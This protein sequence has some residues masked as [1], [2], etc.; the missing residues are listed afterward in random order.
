MFQKDP[1]SQSKAKKFL[2]FLTNGNNAHE[3]KKTQAHFTVQKDSMKPRNYTEENPDE[4]MTLVIT[5]LFPLK[6]LKNVTSKMHP[7]SFS[8]FSS[9]PHKH[10]NIKLKQK[11]VFKWGF[12]KW[13]KNNN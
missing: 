13:G 12:L 10:Q 11:I 1:Q 6:N 7:F 9:L 4:K 3:Y 2:D 5:P 8:F